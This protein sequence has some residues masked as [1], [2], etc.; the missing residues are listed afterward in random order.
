[1]VREIW[2]IQ[3]ARR[4]PEGKSWRGSEE[5]GNTGAKDMC[6]ERRWSGARLGRWNERT[7]RAGNRS[8]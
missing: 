7:G 4:G 2:S 8:G 6:V 5:Q 1:M 3:A